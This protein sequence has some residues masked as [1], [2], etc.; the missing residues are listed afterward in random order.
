V[1]LKKCLP[2]AMSNPEKYDIVAEINNITYNP[3]NTI[4]YIVRLSMHTSVLEQLHMN[5]SYFSFFKKNGVQSLFGGTV[6]SRA[7]ST[8]MYPQLQSNKVFWYLY[9]YDGRNTGCGK[10]TSFF[11]YEMP[12]EKGS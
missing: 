3:K 11:E 10:L 12:Y 6:H 7:Y 4:Y 8:L 1:H 9:V 5:I 2:A